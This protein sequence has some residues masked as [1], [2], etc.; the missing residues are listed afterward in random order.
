MSAQRIAR[1][2]ISAEKLASAAKT[3][4]NQIDEELVTDDYETKMKSID[5]RNCMDRVDGNLSPASIRR[6]NTRSKSIQN[7]DVMS[8]DESMTFA[9]RQ[10]RSASDGHFTFDAMQRRL[11]LSSVTS[12]E[13]F[14]E[15]DEINDHVVSGRSQLDD[16]ISPRSWSD[17]IANDTA[18]ETENKPQHNVNNNNNHK[19]K[20]STETGRRSSKGVVKG[21]YVEDVTFH[22]VNSNQPIRSFEDKDD[23]ITPRTWGEMVAEDTASRYQNRKSSQSE[24]GQGSQQDSSH[25]EGSEQLDFLA[26]SIEFAWPKD[27]PCNGSLSRDCVTPET[28]DDQPK[29]SWEKSNGFARLEWNLR[30]LKRNLLAMRKTDQKIFR[31]LLSNYETIGHLS[32]HVT[33]SSET[34]SPL[35]P[36]SSPCPLTSRSTPSSPEKCRSY[37]SITPMTTPGDTEL[38]RIIREALDQPGALNIR[39][40]VE[41]L[42]PIRR[43]RSSEPTP[44]EYEDLPPDFG[45]EDD[46][47]LEDLLSLS[48]PVFKEPKAPMNHHGSSGTKL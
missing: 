11:G 40:I 14:D 2:K 30:M 32:D 13:T 12:D 46:E 4:N 24:Q 18:I 3:S 21:I 38:F 45:E 20:P 6:K 33:F 9:R 43:R 29:A 48:C 41:Q 15:S 42:S 44:V 16:L 19:N 22:D 27:L 5:L 35:P 31:Q 34:P 8:H 36:S 1:R 10:V 17:M 28:D 23:L 25:R 7:S 26:S 37:S 47:E 39:H